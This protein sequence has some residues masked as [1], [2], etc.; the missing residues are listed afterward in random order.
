MIRRHALALLFFSF[1][2]LFN[3]PMSA[4]AEDSR[5]NLSGNWTSENGLI[6]EISHAGV[7]INWT[8][9]DSTGA[10]KDHFVG[11]VSRSECGMNIYGEVTDGSGELKRVFLNIYNLCEDDTHNKFALKSS[12]ENIIPSGIFYLN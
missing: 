9:Y 3:F 4:L 8:R 6:Y 12:D 7:Y 11:R 10:V 1:I 5:M 2:W